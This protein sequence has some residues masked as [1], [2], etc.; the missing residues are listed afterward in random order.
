MQKLARELNDDAL[1][2]EIAAIR[3]PS[4]FAAVKA[5][6]NRMVKQKE[7]KEA[8]K[9]EI[10]N[11]GNLQRAIADI[12]SKNKQKD[13]EIKTLQVEVK[14]LMSQK[15]VPLERVRVYPEET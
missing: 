12:S 15:R 11:A 8:L 10:S 5:I 14:K 3:D 6:L 9:Q 7:E 4:S 1:N 13:S 2:K